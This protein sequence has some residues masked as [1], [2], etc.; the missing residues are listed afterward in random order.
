MGSVVFTD[1]ITYIQNTFN[2]AFCN[3]TVVTLGWAWNCI[4]G[5]AP[6]HLLN[7]KFLAQSLSLKPSQGCQLCLIEN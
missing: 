1:N 7:M 4:C 2:V 6:S 5:M 3:S